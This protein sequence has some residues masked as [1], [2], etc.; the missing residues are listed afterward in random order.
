MK[1]LSCRILTVVALSAALT[2]CGGA[3]KKE[4][5][6]ASIKKIMPVN[7]EVVA[8]SAVS[9]IPGLFEVQ[10]KADKQPVILYINKNGKLVVSGSIVDVDTK[11]NLTLEAQKKLVGK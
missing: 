7:F 6:A 8:V 2:A 1:K 4:D 11:Q 10:V 5:V 9:G 3:P